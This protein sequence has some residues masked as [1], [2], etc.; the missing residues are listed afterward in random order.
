MPGAFATSI[1]VFGRGLVAEGT[2]FRLTRQSSE[3]V[4]ALVAYVRQNAPAFAVR[5]GRIVFSGGW[6]GAA[7]GFDRPPRQYREGS[8]MRAQAM[9]ADIGGTSLASYADA[10]TEIESDSTLEN[11]LRVKEAGY[12]DGASFTARNPLGLV[13]HQEHMPRINYLIRK[14]FGMPGDAIVN[15]AAPG[16]ESY[17]GGLPESVLLPITRIVLLGAHDHSSLR[18]RHRMLV[19]W[20]HRLRPLP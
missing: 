13:G 18:G 14:A 12:F 20:S 7:E 4:E 6:A 8:L 19:A 2:G 15:I 11:V 17:G 16:P 9:A 3:R 1:I 10:Y 5:R